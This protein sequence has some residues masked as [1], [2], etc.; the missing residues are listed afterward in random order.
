ME[1]DVLI[2]GAGPAGLAT[3]CHLAQLAAQQ[4]QTVSICVLEKG[5]AV[6]AHSISGALLDPCAL[7]ELFPDWRE[8]GAPVTTAVSHEDVVYLT[9]SQHSIRVPD[10]LVPTDT[11]NNGNYVISLADLC[12]WLATQAEALGIEILAGFSAARLLYTDDGQVAG[13]LTGD[14]GVEKNGEPGANYTPGY[15]LRARYTVLAEGCRGHLGKE[16]IQR[17]QLDKDRTP[18]HYGLSIKEV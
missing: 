11:H 15:E 4:Q 10:L 6:G 8:R 17:Y 1:F 12:R 5:A 9:S 3:A 18:Q 16:V 2:V 13:V 7:N 14:Q